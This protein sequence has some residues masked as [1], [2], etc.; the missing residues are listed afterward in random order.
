MTCAQCKKCKW[1]IG[2]II[3]CE[4]DKHIICNSYSEKEACIYFEE[5][6]KR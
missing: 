3:I 5:A 1:T 6:M 2:G 4:R